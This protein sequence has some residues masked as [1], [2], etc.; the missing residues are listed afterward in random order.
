MW[1]TDMGKFLILLGPPISEERDQ[2]SSSTRDIVVWT[3]DEA[4]GV[5]DRNFSVAFVADE[6]GELR[7]SDSPALDISTVQGLSPHTPLDMWEGPGGAAVTAMRVETHGG[8]NQA[9]DLARF[10]VAQGTQFDAVAGLLPMTNVLPGS[11]TTQT[12]L[13]SALALGEAQA[14]ASR[15]PGEQVRVETSFEPIP[16]DLRTDFYEA[17]DGTTY[18]AFTLAPAPSEAATDRQWF[19]FGGLVS[20][21]HEEVR[22]S[23]ADSAQFAAAGP[24]FPGTFQTGLGV[25]PGRYRVLFGLRAET[26]GRIGYRQIDVTVPDLRRPALAL[27]SLTLAQVLEPAAPARKQDAVKVPFVLGGLRV[28]P[29][30]SAVFRNGEEFHLYYQV[31]GAGPAA[32]GKPSL[33]IRYRFSGRSGEAWE[34]IGPAIAQTGNSDVQAWSFPLRGWPPGRFRLSVEVQDQARGHLASAETE[35][36]IVD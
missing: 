4:P 23:F 36:T 24:Q 31:Y 13:G 3:Y 32:D 27:S 14:L 1:V 20:L 21:D 12:A 18:A 11:P 8:P 22:Y 35:F 5:R 29:R 16:V 33:A 26:D 30:P 17:A 7:Q 34:D 25:D 2:V 10:E 6:S 9:Y 19:P 28:V 15:P